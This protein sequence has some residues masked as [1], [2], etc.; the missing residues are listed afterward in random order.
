MRD[1]RRDESPR[2][3]AQNAE[4]ESAKCGE[5]RPAPRQRRESDGGIV[6][7]EGVEES[8]QERCDDESRAEL[9]SKPVKRTTEC[10]IQPRLN[11]AAKDKFL[12]KA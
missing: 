2:L 7:V 9:D 11:V 3:F 8:E 1:A 5:E 10:L 12:P 6:G 4:E